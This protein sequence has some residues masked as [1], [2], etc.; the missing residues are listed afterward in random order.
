[1]KREKSE[2]SAGQALPDDGKL[3]PPPSI[4]WFI[5]PLGA[6]MIYALLTR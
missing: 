1:M 6:L 2:E 5:I 3:H 4:L